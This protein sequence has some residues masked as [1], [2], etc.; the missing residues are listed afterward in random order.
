M[1]RFQNLSRS[2]YNRNNES[3][4]DFAYAMALFRRGMHE[5]DVRCMLLEHRDDWEN[6]SRPRQKEAYLITVGTMNYFCIDIA[7]S[8]LQEECGAVKN[9]VYHELNCVVQSSAMVECNNS[10]I[11]PYLNTSRNQITQES[12]N[13]IMFYHNHRRY[14]NGERAGKMPCEILTGKKQKK[15]WM[16]LLFEIIGG[17]APIFNDF[18]RKQSVRAKI[19]ELLRCHG[20]SDDY[21][22]DITSAR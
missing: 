12:L 14:K 22:V 15:D 11:R 10:I 20:G 19:E 4:T 1:C 17:N 9:Q 5:N 3:A 21:P 13:L 2:S 8:Y 18:L 16:D 6:H 7:I